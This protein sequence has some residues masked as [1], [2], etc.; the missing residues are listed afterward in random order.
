M[1]LQKLKALAEAATP[2]PWRWKLNESSKSVEI[3]GGRPTFDKTV[4]DFVRWGMGRAAPRFNDAVSEGKY[5]IMERVEKYGAV[6][7]GREHH[8]DWFKDV[9]HPDASFMVATDPKT[10]LSMIASIEELERRLAERDA[11]AAPAVSAD[12]RDAERYRAIKARHGYLLVTRMIGMDGYRSH[13]ASQQIDEWA[14]KVVAE[15]AAYR[16]AIAVPTPPAA[17]KEPATDAD[18]DSGSEDAKELP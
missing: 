2:G 3:V 6:V 4:M 12:T 8:S 5:N 18:V 17:P 13:L 16:A 10:V 9:A 15:V 11:Q 7:P 14:D 1:D